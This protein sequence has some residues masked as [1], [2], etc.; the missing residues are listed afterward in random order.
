MLK[1]IKGSTYVIVFN[2][3]NGFEI[4]QG[5]DGFDDPFSLDFPSILDIGV[6]GHCLNKCP[7]CYQGDDY[8]PHMTLEFFKKIL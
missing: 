1:V 7:L 5:I 3:S 8:Q 4:L 6:A 2:T